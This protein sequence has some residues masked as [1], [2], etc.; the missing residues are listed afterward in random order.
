MKKDILNLSQIFITQTIF[1]TVNNFASI[2]QKLMIF[3][4]MERYQ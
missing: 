3:T 4:L 2:V 1:V